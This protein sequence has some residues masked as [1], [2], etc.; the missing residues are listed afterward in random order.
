ME[1][2][3]A[4]EEIQ[5][6]AEEVEDWAQ[7][8][9]RFGYATR[10]VIFTFV[11]ILAFK[12]ALGWGGSTHG[13]R[14]ALREI[15]HGPF[16]QILLLITSVGLAGYVVWRFTQAILDPGF[17]ARGARQIA[18]RLAFAVSGFFYALLAF[19]AAQLA[20]GATIWDSASKEE[21]TAWLLSFPLGDWLVA[22]IGIVIVGIGLHAIY[23]GYTT[24]FMKLYRPEKM[25]PAQKKIAKHVGMIGLSALG[26]TFLIIGGLL[27][28]GGFQ[29][30]PSKATGIGGAL[31]VLATQPHGPYLLGAAA[32]GFMAYG[33][34]CF[35]L[36]RFRWV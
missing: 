25:S 26:I 9:T 17:N 10:G 34:H 20:L 21:W 7:R 18:R 30:N 6:A 8:W 22:L 2:D 4:K 23:R 19:T 14:G 35:T 27:I 31:N 36:G 24:Q 11:G 28:Q 32:V 5:Q 3:N 29:M 12:V 13:S 16:G 33:L 1:L 15:G